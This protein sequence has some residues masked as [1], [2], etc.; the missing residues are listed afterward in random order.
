MILKVV[1]LQKKIVDKTI[2]SSISFEQENGEILG[3]LGPNGSGKTI[4][5]KTLLGIF[6]PTKGEITF[7]P[8][9]KID[10]YLNN[11]LLFTEFSVINNIKT[12]SLLKNGNFE[13]KR[14]NFLLN[15]FGLKTMEK[16]KTRKLSSGQK[17]RLSLLISMINYDKIDLLMLDE[18]FNFIDKNYQKTIM[19]FILKLKCAKIITTHNTEMLEKHFSK[20]IHFGKSNAILTT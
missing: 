10:Y 20:V 11:N 17:Q 14:I 5:I 13:N 8:N 3:I 2:F 7:Q 12:Y 4:F 9:L 18:P 1:N 16:I 6:E 15:V 19:E